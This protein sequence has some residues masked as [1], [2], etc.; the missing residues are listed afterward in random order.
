MRRWLRERGSATDPAVA[1][2]SGPVAA[3]SRGSAPPSSS[4][5]S[6]SSISQAVLGGLRTV[7]SAAT[8]TAPSGIARAG[9]SLCH[10][11]QAIGSAN[12]WVR[13]EGAR[14]HWSE[15]AREGEDGHPDRAGGVDGRARRGLHAGED[16]EPDGGQ[17]LGAHQGGRGLH[18]E[19]ALAHT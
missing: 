8:A 1:A 11:D 4:S 5:S 16:A 9:W 6:W 15:P 13:T 10:S 17:T 7:T 12:S 19:G 18:G 14:L 2:G 3:A